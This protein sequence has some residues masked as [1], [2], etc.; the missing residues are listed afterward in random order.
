MKK[1]NKIFGYS[2]HGLG[3]TIASCVVFVIVVIAFI[4]TYVK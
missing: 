4:I 3:V 1:S 2:K